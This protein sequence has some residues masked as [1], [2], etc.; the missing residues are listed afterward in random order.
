MNLQAIVKPAA[1]PGAASAGS[2]LGR[3]APWV[4]LAALAAFPFLSPVLGSEYYVSFM[5][6]LFIIVLSV[7]SLNFVL[8]YGGLVALGQAGFVGVGAYTLVVLTDAGVES[9]W[10]LWGVATLGAAIASLIVGAISLRTRGTYF[11]MITLAFAQMIYYVTVSLSA[12]GGDDGYSI[13]MRPELGLGLD[14]NDE[15]TLYWVVLALTV[16]VLAVLARISHSRFGKALIGCRDNE[17]RML[18]M[19]YPVYR[20]RLAAFVIAGAVA[21]LSGA[22]LATHNSFVSPSMIHWT[23][24]ATVM[25]IL[26]LGGVGH[27]WGAVVGTAVWLI[28]EET[29]RNYTDFWHWP[30]GLLLILAVFW[31]PRGL[32]TIFDGRRKEEA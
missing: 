23:Q 16:A 25:V 31:K 28:L 18:A 10:V 13:P 3:W 19:G 26:V 21:G 27:R 12:Y 8:G 7:A 2:P 29:L 1:L 6:R 32:A 30:L 20:I 14:S 4:L 11:I 17:T 15:A 9:A 24:S 22:L 5:R